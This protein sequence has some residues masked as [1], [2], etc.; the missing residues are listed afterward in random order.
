MI[1]KQCLICDEPAIDI[2]IEKKDTQD[3]QDTKI[4]SGFFCKKCSIVWSLDHEKKG[5]KRY[6]GSLVSKDSP[7]N[8]IDINNPDNLKCL[9]LQFSN[10]KTIF[11]T[12]DHLILTSAGMIMSK[13]ITKGTQILDNSIIG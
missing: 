6:S 2:I 4:Q 10:G 12:E 9:K 11:C 8:N 3:T 13:D 7:I 5:D 1:W